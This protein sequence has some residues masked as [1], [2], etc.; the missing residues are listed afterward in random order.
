MPLPKVKKEKFGRKIKYPTK[1]SVEEEKRKRAERGEESNATLLNKVD[2]ALYRA[3]R[4]FGV[5]LPIKQNQRQKV[6][7]NERPV[8]ISMMGKGRKKRFPAS[9]RR[10]NSPYFVKRTKPAAVQQEAKRGNGRKPKYPSREL[11]IVALENRE[12]TGKANFPSV[13][14]KEDSALYR[15]SCVFEV[16]LPRKGYSYDGYHLG[17]SVKNLNERDPYVCGKTGKVIFVNGKVVK[18]NFGE[19][20]RII[21]VYEKWYNWN[22][23]ILVEP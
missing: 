7:K 6:T 15:C 16:E 2:A 23:I 18:V 8:A 3:A 10:T 20:G 4:K 5:E 19:P 17:D 14:Q 13:L 21:R 22:N 9:R 1:E 11:G 12:V